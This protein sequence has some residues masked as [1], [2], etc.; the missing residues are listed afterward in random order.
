MKNRWHLTKLDWKHKHI[1]LYICIEIL[2]VE[3]ISLYINPRTMLE[4]VLLNFYISVNI[5]KL[6]RQTLKIYE[7][8]AKTCRN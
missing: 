5:L 7:K 3:V 1:R 6:Y 4:I 2:S 8:V